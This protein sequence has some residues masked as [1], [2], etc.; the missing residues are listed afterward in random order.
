MKFCLN[1]LVAY[2]SLFFGSSVYAQTNTLL[3]Q[4]PCI[5][6]GTCNLLD[7]PRILLH[8]ANFIIGGVGT[9]AVLML[10]I[11]GYQYFFGGIK[12]EQ[13]AKAKKTVSYAMGAV[14][15][16]AFSWIIANALQ[17]NFGS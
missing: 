2:F 3:P 8:M 12:D 7:L 10:G 6:N 9:V 5:Q 14:V 11:A 15:L 16:A 17:V 1:I 13:K 4:D